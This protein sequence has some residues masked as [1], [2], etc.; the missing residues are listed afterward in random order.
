MRKTS[1]RLNH[2]AEYK[3]ACDELYKNNDIPKAL[4]LFQAEAEKGN[5][6]VLHVIGKMY[7]NGLLGEEN[8]I[9]SDGYFMKALNGFLEI[10]PTAK[11]LKPYAQYRIRK[12]CV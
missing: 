1:A 9:K 10:E 5:I 4:E 12:E 7:R 2:Q 6:L 3:S 8:I 11:R